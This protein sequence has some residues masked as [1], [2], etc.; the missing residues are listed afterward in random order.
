M[1]QGANYFFGFLITFVVLL[2]VFV[3][4]GIS[5]RRYFFNRGRGNNSSNSGGSGFIGNVAAE[6]GVS[7]QS[8][9]PMFWEAWVAEGGPKWST[10]AVS[11]I[12]FCQ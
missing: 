8:T 6:W 4:C 12:S 10:M 3:A 7:S 9:K 2:L 5:S 1:S 11:E